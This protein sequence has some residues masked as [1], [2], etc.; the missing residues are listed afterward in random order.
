MNSNTLTPTKISD[1]DFDRLLAKVYEDEPRR[2]RLIFAMDATMSRQP[3]WDMAIKLQ[4]DMF[5]AVKQIGGL[6]VQLVFFRGFD[7]T[8]HSK[9]LDNPERLVQLMS[10]IDC[11]GGYTQIRKVLTHVRREA[12]LEKVNAV[13]YVGDCMEEDVDELCA[14]SA[15]LGAMKVP[16]FMFQEGNDP[17]AMRAFKEIAR[18]TRGAYCRFDAG[19]AKQL[20]GLLTAVAVYAT[21]G[22][23]ALQATASKAAMVF[24]EQLIS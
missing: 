17:R 9:W 6:D 12:K 7:E 23:K 10:K 15:E 22:R 5:L 13:V 8:H 19:S 14:R 20:R 1:E 24:L 11:R 21:G 16:V 4:G 18:L 3:T 2:G